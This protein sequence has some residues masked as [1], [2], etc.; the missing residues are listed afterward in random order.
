MDKQ[1][2]CKKA[3]AKNAWNRWAADLL[4][5]KDQLIKVGKCAVGV[6]G[7]VQT[8]DTEDWIDK[9][10]ADFSRVDKTEDCEINDFVGLIFPCEVWFVNA[11]V[12]NAK[13]DNAVFH[14]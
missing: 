8:Q 11:V 9:A 2:T 13:F 1:E 12:R 4:E 6:D 5:K 10:R 7:I 14:D 3:R